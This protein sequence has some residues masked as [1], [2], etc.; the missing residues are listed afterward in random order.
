M[1]ADW[2]DP[3]RVMLRLWANSLW[4]AS[5]LLFGGHTKPCQSLSFMSEDGSAAVKDSCSA[6]HAATLPSV[7]RASQSVNPRPLWAGKL[8]RLAHEGREKTLQENRLE[9]SRLLALL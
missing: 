2:P 5:T 1:L 3:N 9:L 7:S 8:P 4:Q 6:V